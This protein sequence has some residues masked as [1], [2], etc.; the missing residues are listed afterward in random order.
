MNADS[1]RHLAHALDLERRWCR[2]NGYRLPDELP[3]LAA[4]LVNGRH[5][6]ADEEHEHEERNDGVVPAL[7]YSYADAGRLLG[8]VSTSTVGRLVRQGKLRSIGSGSG[9]RIPHSE[10]ERYLNQELGATA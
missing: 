2:A 10:L 8:G 7:L 5:L 9:S 1:L 3:A 6:S 4:T